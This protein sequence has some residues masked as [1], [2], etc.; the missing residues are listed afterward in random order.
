MKDT[1]AVLVDEKGNEVPVTMVQY[2]PVKKAIKNYREK[3]RPFKLLETGVRTMDTLN[4]M[5]KGTGFIPGPF[6][7][8]KP[9][10][11]CI[12]KTRSHIVVF[13]ACGERANR[14]RNFYRVPLKRRPAHR[15]KLMERT[16]I[17][18]NTSNMRGAREA[19]YIRP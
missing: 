5:T 15:R 13:A 10:S 12:S 6:G 2:W 16:S 7:S 9:C 11:A 3:P 17:L 19:S 1:I 14:G 4:P 8:G 18:A